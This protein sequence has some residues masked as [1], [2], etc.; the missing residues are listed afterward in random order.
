MEESLESLGTIIIAD[1][2]GKSRSWL[3]EK[4]RTSWILPQCHLERVHAQNLPSLTFFYLPICN[5]LSAVGLFVQPGAAK[6]CRSTLHPTPTSRLR[7]SHRPSGEDG[8]YHIE[9]WAYRTPSNHL[10]MYGADHLTDRDR[11]F[12]M[13]PDIDRWCLD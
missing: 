9:Q 3:D 13:G 4:P 2:S 7:N 11:T 6:S 1:S 10:A 5:G 12:A 8:K